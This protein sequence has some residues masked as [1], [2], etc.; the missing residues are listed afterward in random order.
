MDYARDCHVLNYIIPIK[1]HYLQEILFGHKSMSLCTT[2]K[3]E[4]FTRLIFVNEGNS[5]ICLQTFMLA[6]C[7]R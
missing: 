1:S 5:Q 6:A 2:I 4:T 3:W 7:N